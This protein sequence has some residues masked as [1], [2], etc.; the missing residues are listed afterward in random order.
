MDIFRTGRTG[1]LVAI[2][3]PTVSR[4]LYSKTGS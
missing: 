1:V 2:I 3:S 4:A